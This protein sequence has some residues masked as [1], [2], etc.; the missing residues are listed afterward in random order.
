MGKVRENVVQG[1]TEEKVTGR[2][3]AGSVAIGKLSRMSLENVC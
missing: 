2:E 3:S 1:A